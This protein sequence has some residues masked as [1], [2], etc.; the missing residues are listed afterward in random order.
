RFCGSAGILWGGHD[1]GLASV[2]MTAAPSR[3]SPP[4]A[5]VPDAAPVTWLD[6]AAP[7]AC[8][9]YLRLAR[10]DRPIGAWLLLFP[11]WWGQSL[12]ELS[13]RHPPPQPRYLALVL[14]PGFV[15][16]GAGCTY[17]DIVDKDYDTRVARTAARPLPS[18][19]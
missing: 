8:L 1:H 9:P 18:G 10:F 19:Q 6:G 15:M 17:N 14:C 7:A 5:R 3:P 13:L 11:C 4:I 2:S 12:A 16:R